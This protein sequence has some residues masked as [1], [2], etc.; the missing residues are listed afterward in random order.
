MRGRWVSVRQ[1]IASQPGEIHTY[2][3]MPLYRQHDTF[4]F[5]SFL[6]SPT[7]AK[8]HTERQDSAWARRNSFGTL[9]RL[10]SALGHWRGGN[11][12]C[13]C[14]KQRRESMFNVEY[15]TWRLVMMTTEPVVSRQRRMS[16][17]RCSK[18][19]LFCH[20]V[21]YSLNLP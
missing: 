17:T 4:K 18:R 6:R 21:G 9:T 1:P 12:E 2:L 5:H 7:L 8:G 3:D 14:T 16:S 19:R 11:L 10:A 15:Q 13:V 20:H